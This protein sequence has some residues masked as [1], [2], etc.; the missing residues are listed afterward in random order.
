MPKS[1]P[2]T[3][4]VVAAAPRSFRDRL[5]HLP[6]PTQDVA[7]LIAAGIPASL[8]PVL[9][10][11][12]MTV[13][14][15]IPYLAGTVASLMPK[16]SFFRDMK[17]ATERL[18][19]AVVDGEKIA[20]FGDYDVDGATSSA[21]L[22]R[23]LRMLG[24]D[25][26]IYIP[27]RIK[28]G[29]GP[30]AAALL[31]LQAAGHTLVCIL[32]SGTTAFEP[33]DIVATAGLDVIVIDH[34]AAEKALPRA[35]AI[36]NPNRLDQKKGFGYLCAAA[37]TF[38]TCVALEQRLRKIGYLADHALT[39]DLTSLLDLV[40]LG[41]VADV[42]PLVGLN[43]AFVQHGLQVMAERSNPGISALFEVAAI[44][45]PPDAATCGFAFGPRINAGGRVGEAG[46]GACLLS[47]DDKALAQAL[48][49]RLNAWNAERKTIEKTCREDAVA[50]VVA[51]HGD[52]LPSVLVV[53]GDWHEGVIG[54][55]ASRLKEVYDRPSFV[56]T[57]SDKLVKGSGRSIRGFDMGAAVIAARNAG[58]LV[59]GGGHP[60]AAGVSLTPERLAEFET[61]LC[62]AADS[63]EL[64]R[65]GIVC[66]VDLL[67]G[68]DQ[69]S[70]FLAD[71]FTAMAP[72][73]MGNPQ[74]RVVLNGAKILSCDVM[75]DAH[76]RVVIISPT[77]VRVKGIAF[78]IIGSDLATKLLASVGKRI[79]LLGTLT[80]NEWRDQR[81]A[82]IRFEDA[83][84]SA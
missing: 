54:I 71:S 19:T 60:M 53:F 35:V 69:A 13:A 29:Y 45:T 75:K 30:N 26:T 1:P 20:V 68:C 55:I 39:P 7:A 3:R 42:V 17:K 4:G 40:A 67:L 22:T 31:K 64:G 43:R 74:P 10:T 61:W 28:E 80:I 41:T 38:V 8:A 57:M 27:D 52:V 82:E 66:D 51:R 5:W 33:L 47:T 23:F 73:G 81:T 25:A 24:R 6:D 9:A 14:E 36:V 83:R 77:G 46:T 32:D 63:S 16:P 21:I 11:R 78:N 79:D 65:V 49:L 56:M 59:K 12:G 48:A 58:I 76:L 70:V 2:I 34:H 72:F 37:M 84:L 62:E 15:G 18:A 44:D 50:Q